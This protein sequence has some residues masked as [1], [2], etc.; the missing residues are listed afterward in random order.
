MT[1]I[2]LTKE[3]GEKVYVTVESID[4]VEEVKGS[5][6]TA[7]HCRVHVGGVCHKVIE[8]FTVITS[9]IKKARGE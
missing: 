1:G 8:R 3:G 7:P 2:E 5:Y 6:G 9:G 4:S